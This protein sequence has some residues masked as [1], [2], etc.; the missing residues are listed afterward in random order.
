MNVN[1][2][3]IEEKDW[4]VCKLSFQT[5]PEFWAQQK[6]IRKMA[7]VVKEGD[8]MHGVVLRIVKV[9]EFVNKT[10]ALGAKIRFI[11]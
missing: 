9:C 11:K 8:W 5:S 2:F 3:L 6:L 4:N 7:L 1:L 10:R